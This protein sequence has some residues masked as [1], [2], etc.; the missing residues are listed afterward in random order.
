VF[1]PFSP[2]NF[3]KLTF[4]HDHYLFLTK[5]GVLYGSG[6]NDYGDI[7][8]GEEYEYS[9]V[10]RVPNLTDF[11]V[12]DISCTQRMSAIIVE[13]IKNPG[14][15][16]VMVTGQKNNR[17][18]LPDESANVKQFKIVQ[19]LTNKDVCK[20]VQNCEQSIAMTR[21]GAVYSWGDSP[22]G[23]LGH[24]TSSAQTSPKIIKALEK[25]KVVD[26]SVS[27]NLS[28]FVVLNEFNLYDL[29]GCG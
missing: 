7:G 12:L 17:L 16:H 6:Y 15:N 26:V 27:N 4:Y 21:S 3:K 5:Q 20:I 1:L 14:I 13:E 8:C 24:G 22:N 23:T 18:G 19:E 9:Y 10:L 2:D 11:K 28:L 25:L 29:Y